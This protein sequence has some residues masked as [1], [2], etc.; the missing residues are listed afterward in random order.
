MDTLISSLLSDTKLVD[1]FGC[2]CSSSGARA[3]TNKHKRAH[4]QTCREVLRAALVSRC[5]TNERP[6]CTGACSGTTA[7]CVEMPWIE[8]AGRVRRSLAAPALC[9]C[10]HR[11]TSSSSTTKIVT[12]AAMTI[13]KFVVGYRLCKRSRS[14]HKRVYHWRAGELCCRRTCALQPSENTPQLQT[15]QHTQAPRIEDD[16][17]HCDDL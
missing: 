15:I 11:H 6:R 4:A 14:R 16:R 2:S 5:G 8:L 3:Q 7:V 17:F 1:I 13:H 12:T 10:T 9:F